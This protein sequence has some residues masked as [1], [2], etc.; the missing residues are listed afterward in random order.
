MTAA[1]RERHALCD[2]MIRLGPDA[3]TLCGDW[4]ARDLAVHLIVRESRPD[5]AVGI[6]LPPLAG[7]TESVMTSY[8]RRPWEDLVDSVRNGPPVWSPTRIGAVDRAVNTAEFFVH[9]E[10]VRRAQSEWEPR[11]LDD[12]LVA[13]LAR[14][15]HMAK[16]LTSSAPGGL[17]FVPDVGPTVR[18]RPGDPTVTVSGPIG[19]LVLYMFGRQSHSRAEREGPPELISATDEAGFG[20]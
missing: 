11:Q 13:D 8:A 7:H 3:P 6:L 17:V 10:D 15:L 12:D 5:A 9:H 14:P 1:R 19:E 20:L 18:A 16:R 4:T 2:E